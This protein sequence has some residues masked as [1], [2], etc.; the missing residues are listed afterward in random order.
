MAGM[1]WIVR[2]CQHLKLRRIRHK[3]PLPPGDGRK[4]S[5]EDLCR[6]QGLGQNQL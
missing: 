2:K 4:E 6:V 1:T 3:V 5:A